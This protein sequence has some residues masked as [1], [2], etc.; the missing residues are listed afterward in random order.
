[1]YHKRALFVLLAL[2]LFT[3]G[4]TTTQSSSGSDT[5]TPTGAQTYE[6]PNFYYDFD[7]ILVPRELE[8]QHDESYTLDNAKFKAAIM[9]FTGR[10]VAADVFTFFVNNMARDNWQLINS[11]RGE[12]SVLNFEKANKSCMIQIQDDFTTTVTI[13]AVESKADAVAPSGAPVME[14]ELPQ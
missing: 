7:D 3:A 1:M 8:F 9:V 5:T 14:S 12:I 11:L 4:C 13:F 2:F 6:N 10:V